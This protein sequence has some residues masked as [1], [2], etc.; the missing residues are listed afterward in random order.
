MVSPLGLAIPFGQ[1]SALVLMPEATV[2]FG[3]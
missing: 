3:F 2:R 1:G